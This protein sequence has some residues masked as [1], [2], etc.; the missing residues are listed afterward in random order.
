MADIIII[1]VVTALAVLFLVV[2]LT[3][4]PIGLWIS[5]IAAGVKV[6]ILSLVGMRLR[7]VIPKR[8][9]NPLIK[10]RKA[11]LNL[12]INE[13]EAHV[14]AGGRVEMVVDAMIAA[15][16]ASIDL[17][18]EK[19]AAIELS[20]RDVLEAVRNSV[21][22]KVIETPKIS[23]VALDGIEICATVRI[24]VRTNIAKLIGGAGE[25][26][27][28]AR[29]GEGIISTVGGAVSHKEVLKEP[30]VI[31]NKVL[32]KGLDAGTAYEILS[33]DIA[34]VDVGRNVGAR[35]ATEQAEADK[36]Q[37]QAK[38]EERHAA[39][40]ALEQEMQAEVVS[41]QKLV[42]EAIAHALKSGNMGVMDYYNMLNKQADTFMKDNMPAAIAGAVG[43]I[44]QAGIGIAD[45]Y[46]PA[47]MGGTPP[48][49]R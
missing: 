45:K 2:F 49:K 17:P 3:F 32:S 13:L 43:N 1:L 40:K 27:V 11:G 30:S 39:A 28:I 19:A 7:R 47:P 42:P 10:G 46:P 16:R 4:V 44:S 12:Q 38:A 25:E 33:I 26:T 15:A 23:A 35:L 34:D 22:P 36:K 9:I 41:A 21:K 8:V 48:T 29:V 37:A 14:L 5:A 31:S 24:T 6:K 20:G 18:F